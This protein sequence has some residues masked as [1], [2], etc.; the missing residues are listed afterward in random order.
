MRKEILKRSTYCDPYITT[1]NAFQATL[2]ICPKRPDRYSVS[3]L[4]FLCSGRSS[5]VDGNLL[6]IATFAC[7]SFKKIVQGN[8]G[9]HSTL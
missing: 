6:Q 3:N 9:I 2:Y 8:I 7:E 1:V 5:F 4:T